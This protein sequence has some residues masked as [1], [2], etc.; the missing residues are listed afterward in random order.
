[1]F[2]NLTD[3]L[4]N[5]AGRGNRDNPKVLIWKICHLGFQEIRKYN[6]L[7]GLYK[8]V[9]WPKNTQNDLL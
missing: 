1:M 4:L 6:F 9:T 2:Y 3:I 8:I 5:A 7:T